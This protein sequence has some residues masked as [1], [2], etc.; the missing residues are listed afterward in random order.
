MKKVI[1]KWVVIIVVL[2]VGFVCVNNFII[3]KMSKEIE[4]QQIEKNHIDNKDIIE[5]EVL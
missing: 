3:D 1:I 2:T 4:T 5:K